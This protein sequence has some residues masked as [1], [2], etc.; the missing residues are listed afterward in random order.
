MGKSSGESN[1]GRSGQAETVLGKIRVK[2]VHDAPD[3]TDGLRILV[4]RLWPRGLTKEKATVDIWAKELAPSHGLRIWYGHDPSKWQEFKKRYAAEL[5]EKPAEV[6]KLVHAIQKRTAILLY[7]S[8][9]K[10]FNNA[11]ALREYLEARTRKA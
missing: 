7:A 8:K 9:E 5:K 3:E 10:Q 4:D 2:R 11:V 6:E 1:A